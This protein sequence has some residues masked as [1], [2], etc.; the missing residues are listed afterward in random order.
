MTAGGLRLTD[1]K[2]AGL[3]PGSPVFL[4]DRPSCLG[5]AFSFPGWR[6]IS[7]LGAGRARFLDP[8]DGDIVQGDPPPVPG[9]A[10]SPSISGR[11]CWP[12][13]FPQLPGRFD[14]ADA[15]NWPGG[16]GAGRRGE[17]QR[18]GDPVLGPGQGWTWVRSSTDPGCPPAEGGRTAETLPL[19]PSGDGYGP[20]QGRA[21]RPPTKESPPGGGLSYCMGN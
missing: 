5:Q 10:A 3:P 2:N 4:W 13:P 15:L 11:A 7:R 21:K 17:P 8:R 12:A 14:I 9:A 19:L 18:V 16:R 6:I 1:G 20:E